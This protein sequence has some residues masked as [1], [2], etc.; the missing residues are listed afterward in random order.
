MRRGRLYLGSRGFEE[1]VGSGFGNALLVW[2]YSCLILTRLS[3][4]SKFALHD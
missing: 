3:L 1:A 2:L 4:W